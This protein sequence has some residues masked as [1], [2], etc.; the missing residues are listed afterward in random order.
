MV[1]PT[2]TGK[3]VYIIVRKKCRV[4]RQWN[5]FVEM[6]FQMF[7]RSKLKA[8]SIGA[9]SLSLPKNLFM[10][11]YLKAYILACSLIKNF[12]RISCWKN[13]IRTFTDLYS[14]HSLLKLP[15]TWL[16]ISLWASWIKGR[17]VCFKSNKA[18]HNLLH[19]YWKL[20]QISQC[21]FV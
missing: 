6:G 3:S 12:H 18:S 13:W 5:A 1:G 9:F 10:L 16:K 2:G 8:I 17:R 14:W 7:I 11:T 15:P 21:F 20:N 4:L 19:F